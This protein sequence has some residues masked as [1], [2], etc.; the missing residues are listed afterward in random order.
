[1]SETAR[2]SAREVDAGIRRYF[3]L[4]VGGG[5]DGDRKAGRWHREAI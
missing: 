4:G 5:H 1:M 3:V 2:R